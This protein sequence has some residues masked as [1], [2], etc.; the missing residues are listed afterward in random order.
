MAGA[1]APPRRPPP[2]DPEVER[3]LAGLPDWRLRGEALVRELTFRDSD[4]ATDFLEQIAP[5]AVDHHR[6]PDFRVTDRLL[7]IVVSNPH[8][9]GVTLAETRLAAKVD[10]EVAQRLGA[11]RRGLG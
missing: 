9:A 3:A 2:L 4:Q 5:D 1:G 11:A 8:H 10:A 6:R 7:R